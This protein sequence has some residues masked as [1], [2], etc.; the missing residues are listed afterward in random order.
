[1]N[2]QQENRLQEVTWDS[3]FS[4]QEWGKYPGE[5]LIRFIARRFYKAPDRSRIKILEIG[6]GP[7]A[8]IWYLAR[9]G[10]HVYGIDFSAVAIERA[11]LRLGQECPGWKGELIEGDIS[12]LPFDDNYFDAVIDIE[13][14]YC[15]SYEK[16]KQIYTEASRVLKKNGFLFSITFANNSQGDKTGVEVSHNT[17]IASE[18]VLAGKGSAR[19]TEKSEIADLLMPLSVIDIELMTRSVNNFKDEIR[20]WAIIAQKL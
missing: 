10:F 18:G 6:C 5:S 15:N 1:M 20:E 17:W 2:I 3:I 8:N 11:K 14:V 19:F 13:A 12:F 9:E 4:T 7:G 16:S